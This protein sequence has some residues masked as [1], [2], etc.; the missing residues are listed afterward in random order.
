M[1]RSARGRQIVQYKINPN[2]NPN[3]NTNPSS[4]Y[5]IMRFIFGSR[6]HVPSRSK[7]RRCGG[8]ERSS[9]P[10]H[11]L[12]VM[13]D[14]LMLLARIRANSIHTFLGKCVASFTKSVCVH[15]STAWKGLCKIAVKP[16]FL[17]LCGETTGAMHVRVHDWANSSSS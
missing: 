10:V 14:H 11:T 7:H 8:E 4:P 15:L 6:V 16:N 9:Q 1:Y 12:P 17:P 2:P 5:C 13:F 3:P